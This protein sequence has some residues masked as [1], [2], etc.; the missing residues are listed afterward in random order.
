MGVDISKYAVNYMKNNLF[1]KD[2][3]DVFSQELNNF[4]L[5]KLENA[6]KNY[7]FY[8]EKEED[9]LFNI[10]DIYGDVIDTSLTD[11]LA[12]LRNAVESIGF[13]KNYKTSKI[14]LSYGYK[15]I[16]RLGEVF[17]IYYSNIYS[18]IQRVESQRNIDELAD[19]TITDFSKPLKFWSDEDVEGYFP[20]IIAYDEEV[21]YDEE[22]FYDLQ[23]LKTPTTHVAV[24]YFIDRLVMVDG[25]EYT[26][27]NNM[28]LYLK[29]ASDYNRRAVQIQH[30]GGQIS[31]FCD[32][33]G[34]YDNYFDPTPNDYTLP[35]I[36]TRSTL[37]EGF[38]DINSI[39]KVKL[40][41]G[42]QDL[43][44]LA[45]PSLP[46]PTDLDNPIY[47][48]TIDEINIIEDSPWYIVQSMVG[49]KTQYVQVSEL[50]INEISDTLTNCP[51]QRG[52]FNLTYTI[53]N[54][55]YTVSDDG[56]GNIQD[57]FVTGTLEY[58][59]GI[60]YCSLS[61]ST[62]ADTSTEYTYAYNSFLKDTH[63]DFELTNITEIGLLDDSDE[64]VAYATFPPYEYNDNLFHL[65]FQFNI[66]IISYGLL[67]LNGGGS[68][69]EFETILNGGNSLDEFTEIKQGV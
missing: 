6:L 61:T 42:T 8:N 43:P 33:S 13:K 67:I 48:D 57:S 38:D 20:Q 3:L 50:P 11:T 39:K 63:P 2:L 29:S 53:D 7:Y 1:W 27:T 14:G 47:T 59:T 51:I 18:S 17:P 25:T 23:G 62:E 16:D 30:I 54:T 56:E 49:I 68:S 4:K 58:D 35:D 10:S 44:S 31:F 40:G 36:K 32:A 52:G 19:A 65:S 12:F 45:N 66:K 21:W 28:L 24:E 60:L 15:S 46:F 34:L 69:S 22:T 9:I 64:L 26:M 37:K 5:E 41:T 55:T